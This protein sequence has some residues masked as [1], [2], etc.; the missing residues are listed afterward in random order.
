MADT[1]DNVTLLTY[2]WIK[3]R[4]CLSHMWLHA[5]KSLVVKYSIQK[6]NSYKMVNIKL[7]YI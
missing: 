7:K 1:T 4:L 5:M 3:I 2:S 6:E